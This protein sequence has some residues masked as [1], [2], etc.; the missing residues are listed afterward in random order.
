VGPLAALVI[1]AA[2]GSCDAVTVPPS[3][4]PFTPTAPLMRY[5]SGGGYS[6]DGATWTF[7]GSVNPNGSSTDVVL[8]VGSGTTEAPTFDRELPVAEGLI[9]PDAFEFQTSNLIAP[10]CVRFTATNEVGVTSTPALCP[11]A[12][13]LSFPPDPTVAPSAGSGY[14]P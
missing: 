14:G 5:P 1:A 11:T 12:P 2:T 3:A 9:L 7:H 10:F 6:F 4:T 8:E 13:H